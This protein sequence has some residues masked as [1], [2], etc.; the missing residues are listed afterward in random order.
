MLTLGVSIFK[1]K[2]LR[3]AFANAERNSRPEAQPMVALEPAPGIPVQHV[4]FADQELHLVCGLADGRIAVWE[5]DALATSVRRHAALL[6][7]QPAPHMIAPPSEAHHLTALVPNPGDRPALC[8]AVYASSEA[9]ATGGTAYMLD[10]ASRQWLGTLPA[11]GVTA[12]AWSV[13]GKQLVLGLRTGALV[14]LTPEGDTKAHLPPLPDSDRPLYVEDVQW[15]E[16]HVFLVTYNTVS[17]TE[18]PVHEYDV[19]VVVRD[20]SGSITYGAFP[21]DV[22]PPFGDTSRWGRRY[23]VQLHAW[24][25][26]RQLLFI[27]SAPSTDVGAIGCVDGESGVAAWKT[28]ELEETSRP[29]LPFSSQDDASDTAPVA[30]ALD[31]TATEPVPDPNAAVR[32]D[33][34]A[35]TLPATPILYVYTTDGV[36]LAY[37][38][39]NTEAK[40]PYGGMIYSTPMASAPEAELEK[41]AP[42]LATTPTKPAF[43]TT[44]PASGAASKPGPTFG[45]PAFGSTSAFGSAPAFGQSAFGSAPLGG[46]FGAFSSS[47]GGGFGAFSSGKSAFAQSD[48]G[49][50]AE[51]ASAFGQVSKPSAF[52]EGSKPTAFGEGSKPSAF[53]QTSQPS[54]FGQTS[55]SAFGQDTPISDK[56]H[57]TVPAFGKPSAFGSTSTPAFGQT[58]AF[59]GSS[60]FGQSAFGQ[61]S[62]F[63]KTPVSSSASAPAPFSSAFSDMA[64]KGSAFGSVGKPS[65]GSVFGSGGGFAQTK[66]PFEGAKVVQKPAAEPDSKESKD[67]HKGA[68]SF[69]NMGDMLDSQL[70]NA[71]HKPASLRASSTTPI[72]S[73]SFSFGQP[74]SGS[75]PSAEHVHTASSQGTA[76]NKAMLDVHPQR[77]LAERAEQEASKPADIQ[78]PPLT[79]MDTKMPGHGPV[80]D[81]AA[82]KDEMDKSSK[83]DEQADKAASKQ[84]SAFSFSKPEN[85]PTFSFAK[86]EEKKDAPEFSFAKPKEKKDALAFSFAK[87]EKPERKDVSAF[88]LTKPVEKDA[89]AFSS[90]KDGKEAPSFSFAK[91]EKKDAPAFSFTKEKKDAPTFSFTKPEEKNAPTFSFAKPEGRDVP[92]FSF[93]KQEKDTSQLSFVKP[94]KKDAS[95]FS[96]AK[97][98]EKKDISRSSYATSEKDSPAFSFTTEK[99]DEQTSLRNVASNAE[100]A[101][102]HTPSHPSKHIDAISAFAPPSVKDTT[103][104]S[105]LSFGK[106]PSIDFASKPASS[107]DPARVSQHRADFTLDTSTEHTKHFS[108]GIPLD[109]AVPRVSLDDVVPPS[110]SEDGELPREFAKVYMTLNAE[111][112]ALKH[113]AKES[114]DFVSRLSVGENR[115]RRAIEQ[116]ESWRSGDLAFVGNV[117]SE[118]QS[119]LGSLGSLDGP[120][121]QRLAA[122]ESLQL[123]AEVKR[124]EASRFLRARKDPDFAK[125][126]RVRHLGPEHL[127]NQQRLRHLTHIV[128]ER[129]HELG[130]YF[131]SVKGTASGFKAGRIPL[132]APPLDSVYRSTENITSL[133]LERLSQLSR[134]ERELSQVPSARR[135]LTPRASTPAEPLSTLHELDAMLPPMMHAD[136]SA[137]GTSNNEIHTVAMDTLLTARKEPL[138]TKGPSAEEANKTI[139]RL[140]LGHAPVLLT[141]RCAAS[142]KSESSAANAAEAVTT[143]AADD[144]AAPR[145]DHVNFLAT[146]TPSGVDQGRDGGQPASVTSAF[147][148]TP[149]PYFATMGT[150]APPPASHAPPTYT[151]FEGLVGPKDISDTANLTLEEFVRDQSASEEAADEEDEYK[152]ET[153]G[154]EDEDEDEFEDEEDEYD[155]DEEIVS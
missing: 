16:N 142:S 72:K 132:R 56:A 122:L 61:P 71:S 128:R 33:D 22:A 77:N 63:G 8:I 58:S 60:A 98:E 118:L 4:L 85:A 117:T 119:Q 115:G 41:P 105:A 40:E 52:G 27:A 64:N 135:S 93:G 151:T 91:P 9:A 134:L 15:L 133:T 131:D 69:G 44:A 89:P 76:E 120:W 109:T 116:A 88:S 66:P 137:T 55:K 139:G 1:L 130:E 144:T 136:E 23:V 106:S 21:L 24:V 82:G 149:A 80:A 34:P 65:S 113:C 54:A 121:Q 46:G 28:L 48:S 47:S 35:A 101:P 11:E 92:P 37:N 57:S 25:P 17:D 94:D 3:A 6:T 138:L 87:P 79:G 62:A 29:V 102:S 127:E 143:P 38:V 2:T 36:L 51:P 86:P 43:G 140:L 125:L 153:E 152:D 100:S 5:T 154:Y 31:L 39:V 84:E 75:S 90:T 147:R 20:K 42:K 112:A 103:T 124:E 150:K 78:A 45:A 13:R 126:V 49:K 10:V 18:E 123:K 30:L 73:P 12:A 110:V 14:Q 95:E 96:F 145:A 50:P 99:K 148:R 83:K 67:E 107:V 104:N 141:E 111:L 129:M 108:T 32:G 53:G 26:L 74:K 70:D 81:V 146:T 68:L 155:Q 19:F 97:P 7:P 114:G 59:G